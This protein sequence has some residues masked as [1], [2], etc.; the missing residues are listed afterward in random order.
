MTTGQ[1]EVLIGILGGIVGIM[2]VYF[3]AKSNARD[4]L[5][6]I[7]KR[8]DDAVTAAVGPL[9]EQLVTANQQ[10]LRRDRLLERAQQRI[11][12]LEDELRR[13]R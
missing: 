5:L 11:D 9:K 6:L 13:A 7:Q 12:Q 4:N 8:V 2:T 10:I 1:V 3:L